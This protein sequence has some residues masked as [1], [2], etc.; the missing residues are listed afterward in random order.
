M[1]IIQSIK[2][3]G[4]VIMVIFIAIAL[5][6]FILM[7]SKSGSNKGSITSS[8][9]G[10]VNGVS[11]DKAEF[12]RRV[13]AEEGKQAQR[14]G[15]QPTGLELLRLRDQVW[16]Q[17]V[18]ENVFYKEA[19]KL[20]IT[21]SPKELSYILQSDDQQNPLKQ[22]RSLLGADG[23]LDQTKLADALKNIKKAKGDQREA[24]DM[25]IIEPL[26]LSTSAAK[27][28][29][30][31]NASAYYPTW[32]QEK[33]AKE[34]KNFANI[35]YVAV[36]YNEIPDSTITV[37]DEDINGYVAKRKSLFKQEAGVTLSYIAFS[38]LPT[39]PD[40]AAAKKLVEDLKASF[41]TDTSAKLFLARNTSALEYKDEYLPLSRITSKQKDTIIKQ[42]VGSVYGPYI[43]ADNY[44]L[45]KII[46]T[47]QL[48]DSVKA[49]HILIALNDRES[50]KQIMA[51]SVG[52]KLADS[53]LAAVKSGADF[54]ALAVKYSADPGSKIKGGDL[55]TFG[56]G[57]MVPEFNDV[58]FNKPAGTKEKVKTQFG[59]HIIDVQNQSNF[60]T[61]YKIAILAKPILSSD[62]TFNAA[63]Q[64]ATKAAINKNGKSLN[65][66]ASKNGLKVIDVPTTIK[67][68]DFTVGNM[69]DARSLVKWAFG[70]KAGDVSDPI[71]IGDNQIVA[72]VNKIYAEGTQ[73]AAT[74]R[75]M[76]EAAVRN[77]KKAEIIT[78]KLNGAATLEAAATLYNKQ[79]L[80]AGAD[81]S[82]TMNGNIINGIGAEPKVIGASFYKEFQSKAS[83]PIA[84]ASGVYMIKVNSIA[85][86]ADEAPEKL[87]AQIASKTTT[88]RGQTNN[89]FEA[90]KKQSN[91]KDNRS[92]FY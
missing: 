43:E 57:Q 13:K 83:S 92:K 1:Q 30:M 68:N 64:A 12:E 38:Q 79:V 14:T 40:S 78:A 76:A 27:Y 41:A 61:A 39:A 62:S 67:E 9:I 29:G 51:D 85:S 10:K 69:Q 11:I 70:A 90:L 18:A 42:P 47:K 89:W 28:T 81:S 46:G 5:I 17:I 36:Q 2:D 56:Y 72:T 60:K 22:E 66:Y 23:K 49:R 19:E 26:K 58:C 48:P 37:K 82:I 74:A 44:A 91:I 75:P 73:D 35:S 20:G 8:N 50:G 54:A 86:K 88:L 31:L 6:S 45:A 52:S 4:G 33:D 34:A 25:Q 71:A 7:D 24:V 32:M 21:L 15:Q 65:E 53:I 55:G 84:G 77:Q 80:T 87:A 16:S 3:R 63:T 59:Y